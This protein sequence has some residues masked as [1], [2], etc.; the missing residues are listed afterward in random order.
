MSTNDLNQR[1]LEEIELLKKGP[2]QINE[3]TSEEDT[4]KGGDSIH[5]SMPHLRQRRA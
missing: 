2:Q 5:E 1:F 3:Q 4:V